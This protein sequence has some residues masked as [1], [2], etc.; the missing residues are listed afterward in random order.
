[1]LSS[2]CWSCFSFVFCRDFIYHCLEFC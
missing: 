1:V 2:R